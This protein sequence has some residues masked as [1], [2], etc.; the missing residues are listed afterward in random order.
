M[1]SLASLSMIAV[2]ALMG[3]AAV[4]AQDYSPAFRPDAMDDRPVGEPNQVMVLASPHLSQWRD[5]LRP[6]MVEPLLSR[7]VAWQPTAVATEDNSGLLCDMMRRQPARYEDAYRS[8]CFDPS[9]AALATGL[10]VPTANAKAEAMLADWPDNPAPAMRRT[11]AATFLAAGE[12]A[13]ALVQW[14]RL[15]DSQRIADGILTSE[16]VDL[17]K[18]R[19]QRVN[20]TDLIA[21]R[22]AARAGLE[23]VWSVDDQST[24]MGALQDEEAFGKA[25]SRAWDNDASKAR[26]AQSDALASTITSSDGL[27]NLYRAFNDPS[28]AIEAYKSDWGPALADPSPQGYGRRYVAYWETRNLRMVANI[29]EVLGRRAGTR[30]LAIVGASHKGYYEAYLHQMRDVKLVDIAPVLK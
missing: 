29:R 2:V 1:R 10:D 20:E 13:S 3:G 12:P 23:R 11:L 24:Y 6:E 16:L 30:M 18:A 22:V 4:S 15:P 8:Y 28:Y 9:R 21:A 14:L 7:L 27:L 26:K 25:L 17:L 5:R 19:A